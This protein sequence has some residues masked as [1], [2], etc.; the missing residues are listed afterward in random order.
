MAES[1]GPQAA[2]GEPYRGAA[3]NLARTLRQPPKGLHLS[4]RP[5][6]RR[7]PDQPEAPPGAPWQVVASG[8]LQRGPAPPSAPSQHKFTGGLIRNLKSLSPPQTHEPGC[9]LTSPQAPLTSEFEERCPRHGVCMWGG[10]LAEAPSRS[11]RWMTVPIDTQS[12]Q[13]AHHSI[14][15]KAENGEIT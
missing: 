6:Q 5:R 13:H 10:P 11:E 7:S 8:S 2:L 1:R 14:I 12:P 4:K 15:Y 3:A 9:V